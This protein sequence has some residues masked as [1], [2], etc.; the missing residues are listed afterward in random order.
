MNF[1]VR[2]GSEIILAVEAEVLLSDL[3]EGLPGKVNTGLGRVSGF[4]CLRE[5]RN[6]STFADLSDR[7]PEDRGGRMKGQKKMIEVRNEG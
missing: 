3:A 1:D 5:R 4:Y 7:S 2:S 6:Q